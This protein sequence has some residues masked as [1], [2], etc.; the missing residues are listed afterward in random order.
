[1]TGGLF[2]LSQVFI[3]TGLATVAFDSF[4]RSEQKYFLRGMSDLLA[5][6]GCVLLVLNGACR[7]M[8]CP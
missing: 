6:T 8:S 7:F 5:G 3:G 1:M 4:A 2:F